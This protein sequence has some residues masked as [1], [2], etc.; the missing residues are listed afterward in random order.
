MAQPRTHRLILTGPLAGKTI[1]LNGR[2]F[3][4]GVLELY[5]KAEAVEG[6]IT[7]MGRSYQAYLEGSDEL[8]KAQARDAEHLEKTNG[9]CD[10]QRTI[11]DEEGLDPGEGEVQPEGE[12]STSEGDDNG[13]GSA[14]G[15]EG[16][17]GGLPDRDGLQ[18]AGISASEVGPGGP[19]PETQDIALRNA[20]LALDPENDEHWTQGGKPAISAV[21]QAYDS[22][23]VTRKDIQAAMPEWNRDKAKEHKELA[24]LNG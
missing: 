12:G 13:D 16:S 2:H 10:I 6:L 15:S 19:F 14:E 3:K 21:E 1:K 18:N 11:R 17:E 24:D 20:V 22:T 4:E 23:G 9:E 5:G 7:Y 8:R